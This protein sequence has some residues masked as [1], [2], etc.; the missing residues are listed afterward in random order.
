MNPYL[1]EL[2]SDFLLVG[3][4]SPEDSIFEQKELSLKDAK[5]FAAL[6]T[7]PNEYT[8][9]SVRGRF[10]KNGLEMILVAISLHKK[11]THLD[12]QGVQLSTKEADILAK[13]LREAECPVEQLKLRSQ[14]EWNILSTGILQNKTLKTLTVGS[15]PL[16]DPIGRETATALAVLFAHESCPLTHFK[17]VIGGAGFK[18]FVIPLILQILISGIQKS[19]T[20]T[21]LDF[22]DSVLSAPDTI[23]PL[24]DLLKHPHCPIKDLYL[25]NCSITVAGVKLLEDA[26]K[27]NKSLNCLYISD[28]QSMHAVTALDK[29]R[30]ALDK[31]RARQRARQ[32]AIDHYLEDARRHQGHMDG[33]LND[34]P[35]QPLLLRDR[36]SLAASNNIE[37]EPKSPVVRAGRSGLPPKQ[38]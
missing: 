29:Q 28:E 26:L 1:K 22:S 31:Q 7:G 23:K 2:P 30:A 10:E 15:A 6:I 4:S 37:G 36:S 16:F 34:S 21:S 3:N 33:V 32:R 18:E 5:D 13:M 12:L 17:G 19:K 14:N 27:S 20:L 8:H 11:L 38:S 9:I 24:A 35:P 25:Q